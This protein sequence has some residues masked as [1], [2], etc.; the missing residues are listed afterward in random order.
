MRIR[1]GSKY[2]ASITHVVCEL[3]LSVSH[4][5]LLIGTFCWEAETD[6]EYGEPGRPLGKEKTHLEA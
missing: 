4:G 1:A 5:T 2:L 3:D 6:A